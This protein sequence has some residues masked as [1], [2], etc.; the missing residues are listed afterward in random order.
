[1]TPC[2]G[3]LWMLNMLPTRRLIVQQ[4]WVQLSPT[5]ATSCADQCALHDFEPAFLKGPLNMQ[6]VDGCFS[7]LVTL[8]W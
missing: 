3:Q 7:R 6:G 5:E 4:Q 1:M 8:S 2:V